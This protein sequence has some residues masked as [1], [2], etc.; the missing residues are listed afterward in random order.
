MKIILAGI[1]YVGT[2]TLA[3]LLAE[4]KEQ[5]TGEPFHMGLIHDHSKLPHTSG[6][7][8]DTTLEE[9]KQILALS[10]KL[11]EMYHRY[12]MYY[13]I[14]HYVHEDDLTIGFHIEESI[15]ARKYYGYGLPGEQF[16]REKV[17]EQIERRVKQVT[18]DPV[19]IVHMTASPEVIE[20]RMSELSV[21][22]AHSNSP[23]NSEDIP[24]I[25]SEYDRLV[26]KSTIG[27][28]VRLDTSIDTFQ[29]SLDRLVQLLE[30]HFTESDQERISLHKSNA[31][32]N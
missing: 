9:Q 29:Q 31:A 18:S 22:P 4:W 23:M 1:E 14:H 13:H 28:V 27:P 5:T 32:I 16:D 26:R 30:P 24:E 7:P 12:S 19:I 20:Q 17:F 25:M 21:S 8:D 10:P 2:T 15:F 3:N 11:K 6:H